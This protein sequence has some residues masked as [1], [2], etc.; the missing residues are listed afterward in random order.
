GASLTIQI[1]NQ[2]ADFSFALFIGELDNSPVTFKNP[3]APLYPRL[4]HGKSS[5][6]ITVTWTS[7][8]DIDEATPYIEWDWKG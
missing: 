8:Y 1:I 4:A 6:T 2:R 5:N 7:G 3:K